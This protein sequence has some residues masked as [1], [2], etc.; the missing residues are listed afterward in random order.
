MQ[1]SNGKQN[2]CFLD[3]AKHAY[4]M[5]FVSVI[6]YCQDC[7]LQFEFLKNIKFPKALYEIIQQFLKSSGKCQNCQPILINLIQYTN[8]Q[9]LE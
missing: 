8:M 1:F 4:T 9:I 3:Y 6:G 7:W 2:F 5:E